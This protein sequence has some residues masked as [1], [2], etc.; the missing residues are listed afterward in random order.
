MS[1]FLSRFYSEVDIINSNTIQYQELFDLS[2]MLYIWIF[3]WNQKLINL[4]DL[5]IQ[6][7]SI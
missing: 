1:D 5:I 4:N 3:L 2:E 6:S 7:N